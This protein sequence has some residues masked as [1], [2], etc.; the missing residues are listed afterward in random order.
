M[1]KE[2]KII[3]G[4]DQLD[5]VVDYLK[6]LLTICDVFTFTGSL[7]A[8]K[9]TLV[10]LLLKSCGVQ[11]AVISPTFTYVNGYKN[12]QGETFYHFDCYRLASLD[13]FV[14]AGFD[15]YLYE[16]GSW[17]FIEWPEIVMPLLKKR[18]CHISIAH[19]DADSRVYT[20]TVIE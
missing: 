13:D 10:R 19:Q 6:S 17:C 8:G 11:E 3:A 7:G 18:V 1:T 2:K 9:T 14:M 12:E 15:E 5:E 20:L 16:Q 4:P